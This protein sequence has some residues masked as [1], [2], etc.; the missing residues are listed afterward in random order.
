MRKR[1]ILTLAVPAVLL[2]GGCDVDL[3]KEQDPNPGQGG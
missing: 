3:P 1:S 2:L